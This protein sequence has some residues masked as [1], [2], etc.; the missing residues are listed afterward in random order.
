MTNKVILTRR[1]KD[2]IDLSCN[3]TNEILNH[4][5]SKKQKSKG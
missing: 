2:N 1:F 3:R 4:L 5:I